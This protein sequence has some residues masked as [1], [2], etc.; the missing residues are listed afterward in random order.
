MLDELFN[1]DN[2][3]LRAQLASFLIACVKRGTDAANKQQNRVVAKAFDLSSRSGE[4][5][6]GQVDVVMPD[7]WTPASVV[8]ENANGAGT[9]SVYRDGVING[10]SYVD[11]PKSTAKSVPL[12]Q[13]KRITL[14][15]DT[16]TVNSG[17]LRVYLVE[18]A[19]SYSV[20]TIA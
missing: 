4:G 19:Q 1:Q 7:D 2:S 3:E 9:I 8:I 20:W 5:A 10:M 18:K 15:W 16:A 17:A 13:T 11:V 12:P 14:K 6:N